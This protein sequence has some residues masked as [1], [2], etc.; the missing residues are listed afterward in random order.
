MSARFI[1]CQQ[2]GQ[3]NDP[4]SKFCHNCGSALS[5]QTVV[6][7]PPAVPQTAQQPA[8][9]AAPAKQS[10]SCLSSCLIVS[11]VLVCLVV[12]GATAVT[13]LYGDNIKTTIEAYLTPQPGGPGVVSGNTAVSGTNSVTVN[14]GAE[15]VVTAANGASITIPTGAV[16]VMDDGSAGTMVFSIQEDTSI[17]PALPEEFD[18]VGPVYHL[19]PEGFVFTSP[20]QIS[21]PIPQDIDPELVLGL[22]FFDVQANVWKLLPGTVDAQTHTVSA[23]TTHFSTWGIFGSC[24]GDVFGGCAYY[25]SRNQWQRENG[26]WFKVTNNHVRNTGSFPGGRHLPLSTSYGVCI[27]SYAFDNADNAWNWLEPYDWQITASDDSTTDYWLPAGQYELVDIYYMSE[28]NQSPLYVPEYATYW[29]TLGTYSLDPDETIEFTS[30]SV[31][32][33]SFTQG[34]PPCWGEMTTSVGT[35][36]VQITLTWQDYADID[37]YVEDPTGEVVYY[38][39]D[40]VSSGGQLDRDNTCG[41]YIQGQPENIFW[42]QGGAPSGTYKVSVDYFGDCEDAGP[43][44]WTVRTVVGGQVQTYNGTLGMQG[45]NQEVTTFNIP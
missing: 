3:P 12:G 37:L 28:I 30:A 36:D 8:R 24:I 15:G 38:G 17:T 11:L 5:Q 14:S 26:G 44:Q 40:Y 1:Y 31:D 29:R 13:L 4:R 25:E 21:L 27:K 16:P 41:D 9:P 10:R 23:E 45:D 43:V 20:V 7:R 22:T 19:G 34:R 18:P 2:C 32:L 42:P 33:N 39:N 6:A 35:G